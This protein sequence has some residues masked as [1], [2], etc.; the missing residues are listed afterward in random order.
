MKWWK[1][2]FPLYVVACAWTVAVD[3]AFGNLPSH[4]VGRWVL[5]SVALVAVPA[6]CAGGLQQV[7]RGRATSGREPLMVVNP[8]FW[9]VAL[10]GIAP[11]VTGAVLDAGWPWGSPSRFA[12]A[13]GGIVVL[14]LLGTL[15]QVLL[16]RRKRNQEQAEEAVSP[17]S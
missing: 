16:A 5:W 12:L 8:V 13:A 14:A 7:E 6:A 9:A 11:V 1:V 2:F 10:V 17:R 15:V 4:S 3:A